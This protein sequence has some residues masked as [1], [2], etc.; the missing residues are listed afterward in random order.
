M[1][2]SILTLRQI[3]SHLEWA[4]VVEHRLLVSGIYGRQLYTELSIKFSCVNPNTR[5]YSLIY[6][7]IF[8]L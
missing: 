6:S 3:Y 1:S 4:K 5:F 2:Y 7:K 8:E